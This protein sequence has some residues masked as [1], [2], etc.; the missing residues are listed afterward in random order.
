[1]STSQ[2]REQT[3]EP[4]PDHLDPSILTPVEKIT[5]DI[6]N[7]ARMID[8]AE[9]RFLVDAY[10]KSQRDRIRSAHQVRTLAKEGEPSDVVDWLR[11]QSNVLEQSV[12][13]ALDVYSTSRF[14]GEW[15]RSIVGIGPVIAAGLMAHIDIRQAPTAGHIWRFAGLDPTTKWV[16][17]KIRPHNGAL[18]RLCWIVGESFTKFAGHESCLYGKVWWERKQLEIQRNDLGLFA[19]QAKVSLATKDFS[20][21]TGAKRWYQGEYPAG[22]CA[23]L[24][25]LNDLSEREAY[26]K[27]VR[28]EPGQGVA[29]LPPARIHLRAQRYA[30]K[31]F[32]AHYHHVLHEGVLKLPPPR[33]YILQAQPHIHTHFLAPPNWPMQGNKTL[34]VDPD[35]PTDKIN[36]VAAKP[37]VEP[38]KPR[39]KRVAAVTAPERVQG[40][41]TSTAPAPV[42]EPPVVEPP[43]TEPG[44]VKALVVKVG[45][46][47][48]VRQAMLEPTPTPTP[49]PT[50]A[51]GGNGG[52]AKPPSR[53]AAPPAAPEPVRWWETPTTP[54]RRRGKI[55]PVAEADAYRVPD[56]PKR[57]R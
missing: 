13:G 12:K 42:V 36:P 52:K 3:R 46:K 10:Y 24:M 8:A 35:A 39:K 7:A 34:W 38:L 49:P 53:V 27:R 45:R 20:K 16:K 51:A 28:V 54:Q 21:D 26:L 4:T 25:A 37:V 19:D 9:A 30:V 32:L 44:A 23:A 47:P 22:T 29:M 56:A 50:P 57:R 11:M 5:R 48:R 18:K 17:G 1:M 55:G 33:P 41:A 14:D 43:A 40:P 6:K 15:L 2:T 31:L